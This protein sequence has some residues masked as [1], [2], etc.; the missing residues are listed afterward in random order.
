MKDIHAFFSCYNKYLVWYSN[1][2]SWY[3]DLNGMLQVTFKYKNN[4]KDKWLR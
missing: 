2:E 3:Q 4:F 1:I